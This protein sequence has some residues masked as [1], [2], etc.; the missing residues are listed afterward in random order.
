MRS[1]VFGGQRPLEGALHKQRPILKAHRGQISPPD[2]ARV[3]RD[4]AWGH[5]EPKRRPVAYKE[6]LWSVSA[7]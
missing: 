1:L 6:P 7:S 4:E 3:K 5:P 2:A